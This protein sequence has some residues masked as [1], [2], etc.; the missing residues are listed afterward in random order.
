MKP[1]FA[2]G[3]VVMFCAL[4]ANRADATPT[5]GFSFT[6]LG[7]L[8]GGSFFSL[9]NGIS[10]DGSTVVGASNSANGTEAF[11]WNAGTGMTPLGDLPGG[12]FA[13]SAGLVS[14]DGSFVA[15]NSQIGLDGNFVSTRAF[16]WSAP[17]GMVD[18]G[19]IPPTNGFSNPWGMSGDGRFVSGTAQGPNGFEG[20]IF[21]AQS[22]VMTGIGAFE[23]RGISDDGAIASTIQL[24]PHPSGQGTNLVASRW[25]SQTGHVE[26]GLLRPTDRISDPRAMTPD[27]ATI[28]GWSAPTPGGTPAN[29]RAFVW[30]QADGMAALPS[31]FGAP[32]NW[33]SE[34]TAVSADGSIIT[35]FERVPGDN[36]QFAVIWDAQRGAINLQLFLEGQGVFLEGY[37]LISATGVSGDGRTIVGVARDKGGLLEAFVVTIPA[38]GVC[39]MTLPLMGSLRR[40][41]RG[42]SAAGSVG[43]E[44]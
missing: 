29:Q 2:A 7:D 18:L 19:S 33:I 32:S 5:P 12:A 40:R 43:L 34:A 21:D 20:F 11:V 23:A 38:P 42:A 8:P 22:G 39:M 3:A 41:R 37:E 36:E 13:S 27:G 30:T 44:E 6:T 25:T 26:I 14:S 17:S 1:E 24:V 28:V 10:R 4:F 16:G 31:V 15:G 35:G 9:A